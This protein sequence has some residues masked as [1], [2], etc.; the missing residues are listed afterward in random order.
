MASPNL[1]F[2]FNARGRR[3]LGDLAFL[4]SSFTLLRSPATNAAFF[5]E[6]VEGKV[7]SN[8]LDVFVQHSLEFDEDHRL[9]IIVVSG[10]QSPTQPSDCVLGSTH[11]RLLHQ[12]TQR[13]DNSLLKRLRSC[14]YGR[15]CRESYGL[16]FPSLGSR[17]LL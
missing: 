1:I 6:W 10:Q 15:L 16:P 2:P 3:F 7:R 17:L 4:P 12:A 13:R 9:L 14:L 8:A 5:H 11:R